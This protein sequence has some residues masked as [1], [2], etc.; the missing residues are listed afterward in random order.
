MLTGLPVSGQ[1]KLFDIAND[2]LL[3]GSAFATLT[4]T[5]PAGV[6]A[7]ILVTAVVHG[8]RLFAFDSLRN[9]VYVF[10]F[11]PATPDF[12]QLA[13]FV[14]PSSPGLFPSELVV[15]PDGSLLYA[16]LRE[17]D[18][19]AVLDT[20][21]VVAGSPGALLT[22]VATGLA[23]TTLAY[24]PGLATPTGTDVTVQ[25]ISEVT[26]AFNNVTGGGETSVTTTNTNP[27]P[28]PAGFQ[29]G[30]PPVFFE[31]TSTAT[32]TGP[33][34]VCFSYDE[35]Q[36]NGA[37]ADLRV[38][39][40]EGGSFVDRT[41]SLDT[42]NNVICA[43]VDSFSAFVAGL[44]SVNFLFD[45]LVDDIADSVAHD[46][47]RRSLQAK[48]LAARSAFDRGELNA[49]AN[50]LNALKEEIQA[51]TGKHL[52]ETDAARLLSQVDTLISRL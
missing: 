46:G 17:D 27:L 30:D 49:A 23:P 11:D 29:V 9:V 14:I 3:S 39:H 25:P 1:L 33:I 48:A 52:T 18:A 32:F 44:G 43:V 13:A 21:Q 12:S 8:N 38:L 22:T 15:T 42:A 31:I 40:E 41:S 45:S 19:I 50:A 7:V 26:I 2:P 35:N 37:E 6:S 4:A 36:F 10:N 51:Q 16:A 5:P 20:A 47:I 24:R 28:V 34:E